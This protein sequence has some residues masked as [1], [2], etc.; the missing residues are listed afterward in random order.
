MNLLITS[1][2]RPGHNSV[3]NIAQILGY[4]FGNVDA[5]YAVENQGVAHDCS[6]PSE[7]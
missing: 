2:G 5:S 6:R 4:L 3:G 1:E 7:C